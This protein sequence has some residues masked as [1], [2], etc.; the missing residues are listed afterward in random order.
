MKIAIAGGS[1]FLGRH[2]CAHLAA[3]GHTVT[4][5][6]R[7]AASGL[8]AGI[9]QVRW[10][11]DGTTGDWASV[12]DGCD[13]VVNLAGTSI[14]DGRWTRARKAEILASRL[15]AT[16]SLVAA[17][18]AAG[19]RPSVFVSASAQGFYGDRGDEELTEASGVGSGFLA[20]VCRQWE[21]A[22]LAAPAGV[23]VVLL[24]TGLVL[25]SDGGALARMVLPFRLF[26]GG[27]FGSGRQF[28]SWMHAADW[29]AMAAWAIT[30]EAVTG[31]LNVCTP[32]PIRNREFCA[33]LGRALGRPSWL[34]A[35]AFALRVVLGEMA[36]DLLLG[37]IR[38]LPRR[39]LDLGFQCRYP[40]LAT[41]LEAVL[42]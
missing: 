26:A 28:M 25:A 30:T 23:R 20:D 10:A 13:A 21:A 17:I 1:G 9:G 5:L 42:Q 4:V 2:L 36:D 31:P 29:V 6:G 34:P 32:A 39:A 11:P 14:G 35:P 41:A 22:A 33:T 19:R 37:S 7:G 38:M 12:I 8:P 24:R 16:N 15:A 27:P 40:E 3:A 18:A